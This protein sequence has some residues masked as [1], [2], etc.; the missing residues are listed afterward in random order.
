M[1]VSPSG[2]GLG[3]ALMGVLLAAVPLRA[4][5]A[6]KEPGLYATGDLGFL[7]TSGNSKANSLGLKLDIARLWSKQAFRLSAGALRQASAGRIAVGTPT[8]YELEVPEPKTT[9]E[10]YYA[11]AAYDRQLSDRLFY[12]LGA[13]CRHSRSS[14]SSRPRGFPRAS[15]YPP[16]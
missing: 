7:W 6:K 14:P 16:S 3:T 1:L 4:D 8:E 11:R 2:G 10:D 12:S 13:G 5:D 15:R 9:A